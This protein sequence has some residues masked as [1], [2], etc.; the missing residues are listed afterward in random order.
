MKKII[1]PIFTVI[2]TSLFSS[3]DYVKDPLQSGVQTIAND[4]LTVRRVLIEEFTGHY[5]SNCPEAA[6]EANRLVGVYGSQIIPI[7]IHAGDPAF[8]D[9]HPGTGMYETDF[10][11]SDGDAYATGFSLIGQGLPNGIVSRLN[12]ASLVPFA[13]W[14]TEFLTVKDLAPVAEIN[15]TSAY[16]TSNREVTIDVETEWLLD[17]ETGTNYSLQ[18]WMIEDHIIDWQYNLGV[19]DPNYEHRHVFR[20]AVNTTWGEAIATTTQGS[21]DNKSYTYTLNAA[22]DEDNCEIVAFVYKDS[23]DYEIMQAN[24][25]HVK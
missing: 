5:C 25:E 22:W 24:I 7:A 2:L 6:T 13:N 19:N 4:S 9:P 20:G 12:N 8:N 3:C 17:G 18:V 15:I 23:P 16:N 10:T 14:E 1:I 21:K 11:T